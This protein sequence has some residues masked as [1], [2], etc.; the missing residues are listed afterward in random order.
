MVLIPLGDDAPHAR[1]DTP[2][3]T[4]AL[5]AFNI[6]IFVW[7]LSVT[8][9]EDIVFERH[10]GVTPALMFGTNDLGFVE[11]FAPL[12]TYMF[13]HGGWSH[14]IGNMLFLWIFGDD[15]EDALG[16]G[17]F[18]VFYLLCGMFGALLYSALSA[19]P[20]APLVGA[21]GAIAGV[22]SAYLMIRPCA[23]V[24]VL[25]FIKIVAIRAMYVILAWAALQIWHVITPGDGAVAWW[26]HIG[27]MLAG[28]AL[29]PIMKQPGVQLWECIQQRTFVSPWDTELRPPS[30]RGD[31]RSKL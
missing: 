9:G 8:K 14:I 12:V 27:G 15:I 22:M 10:W 26:A 18:I 21:S 29:I 31:A 1:R 25:V 13:L 30:A 6:A 2:Y 3:V 4:Y 16:H 23:H 5:I 28:A 17:R 11:R 20:Q 7:R 24:R 19:H